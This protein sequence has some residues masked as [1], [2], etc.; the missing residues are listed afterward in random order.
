MFTNVL[1]TLKSSN[2]ALL[3]VLHEAS[4]VHFH[5][6]SNVLNKHE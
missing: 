5:L 3:F 6:I 4:M 1:D 2:I